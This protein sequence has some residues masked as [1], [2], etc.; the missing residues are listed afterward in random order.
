MLKYFS[1]LKTVVSFII[2]YL[3]LYAIY[4]QLNGEVSPGGGFQAGVI[5]ASGI[6]AFDLLNGSKKTCEFFSEKALIIC[7]IFGVLIYAS[8][9]L[10]SF[11]FNDN[12]LNYNSIAKTPW[13]NH[14]LTGQH[15]GIFFIEIGVGLTVSS[16][17]CLIYLV[18]KED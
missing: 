6:I 14:P 9:G 4:I 17:M 8:T 12:Y 10:V 5:F 18:L 2:P 16:I 13:V 11:L 3:I 15:I 1:V 7:G